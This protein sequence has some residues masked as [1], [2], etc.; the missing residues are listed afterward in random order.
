M[1]PPGELPNLPG[2]ALCRE[3]QLWAYEPLHVQK[4]ALYSF[5]PQPRS[6]CSLSS[7][8]PWSLQGSEP[9]YYNQVFSTWI[10]S[11]EA[12]L[13]SRQKAVWYPYNLPA[14][15]TSARASCKAGQFCSIQVYCWA[16]PLMAS[17]SHFS[18]VCLFVCLFVL[19]QGLSMKSWLSWN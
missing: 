12:V 19:R 9:W 11:C 1:L 14:I 13:S 7:C 15:N 6:S 5:P 16:I 4:I 3:P 17:F 18:F 10:S 2:L 8:V